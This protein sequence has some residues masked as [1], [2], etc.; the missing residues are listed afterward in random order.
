MTSRRNMIKKT[1]ASVAGL[2]LLPACGLF[3]PVGGG[4][5]TTARFQI[6]I[7]D[8]SIGKRADFTAMEIAAKLGIDG[9]QVSIIK[10]ENEQHLMQKAE[11][12]TYN[13]AEKNT[14][15]IYRG[16]G[17]WQTQSSTF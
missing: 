8:W 13:K 5:L 12:N 17:Y 3:Y 1:A 15:Y 4:E 11:I 2:S 9:V 10:G 6:G 14:S 16:P 7:C